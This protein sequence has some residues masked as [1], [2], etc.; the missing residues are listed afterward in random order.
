MNAGELLMEM[1]SLGARVQVVGE[2]LR[3]EA[4]RGAITSEMRRTLAAHKAEIIRRLTRQ[5]ITIVA[6][7]GNGCSES[8]TLADGVGYCR[9]HRMAVRYVDQPN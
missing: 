2:R 8:I 1:L 6:C 4:R 7:P 5:H 9:N 3:I